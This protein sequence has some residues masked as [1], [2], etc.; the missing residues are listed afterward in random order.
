MKR[1]PYTITTFTKSNHIMLKHGQRTLGLVTAEDLARKPITIRGNATTYDAIEKITDAD[2]S[3]VLLQTPT[4]SGI[5]SQ[6]EISDM[7]LSEE[8]NVKKISAADWMRECT[9]IDKF[10]PISNCADAMLRKKTNTLCIKDSHGIRGILTKHDLVRHYY[11]NRNEAVKISDIMSVGSFFVQ[12]D[13]SL[14]ESLQR[15]QQN[16]ISRL[17]VKDNLDNPIGIVTFKNFL[18]SVMYHSNGRD[19][20]V[21]S[22]GFGKKTAVGQIMTKNIIT[23]PS[24]ATVSKVSKILIE[25]RIHGVAVIEN[26]RIAGFVTEKDVVRHIASLSI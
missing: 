15:M 20:D 9:L 12:N 6:R 1:T 7:L 19:D 11:E 16:Q 17:L 13:M 24:H 18:N 23:V 3:A 8:K 14:Y 26:Q 4:E 10:A 25:Y 5:L 21:F 2:I 22:T